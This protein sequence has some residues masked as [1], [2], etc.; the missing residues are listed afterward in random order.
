M[1]SG[2]SERRPTAVVV[3]AAQIE[4]QGYGGGNGGCGGGR[5]GASEVDFSRKKCGLDGPHLFSDGMGQ[6]QVQFQCNN[7]SV[8]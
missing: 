3:A 1:G 7:P 8:P 4:E 6:K 5:L 2:G